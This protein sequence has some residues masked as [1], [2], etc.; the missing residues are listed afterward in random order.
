MMK[1]E[2]ACARWYNDSYHSEKFLA[3]RLY[4]NEELCRFMGRNW[5]H[6]PGNQRKNIKILELGCGSGSNLWMLKR[7]G[8]DAYGIDLSSE[9]IDLAKQMCE[10]WSLDYLSVT[11]DTCLSVQDMTEL[12]FSDETFDTVL[13][14]FSAFCLTESEWKCC[15]NEVNCVLKK[16]GKFFVYTPSKSSDAF[17]NHMPAKMIDNSTLEGILRET[18]PYYGN[19]YPVR[20]MSKEDVEKSAGDLFEITYFE[21]VSRTYRS[22]L[23]YFEFLVYE[24]TKR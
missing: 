4:P 5:F 3:Q 15:L 8:F 13:D 18:S 10:H 11:G 12:S 9:A 24:L 23:E 16:H 22:G 20:F 7:E 14:I 17:I 1:T 21:K 19:N 2:K 6:L